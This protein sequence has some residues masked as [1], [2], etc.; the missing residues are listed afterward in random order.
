MKSRLLFVALLPMLILLMVIN[1][2]R[3]VA[4]ASDP[5]GTMVS[6]TEALRALANG[7][8]IPVD[9]AD[10]LD[11]LPSFSSEGEAQLL[12]PESSNTPQALSGGI[13]FA[14][15]RHG[16]F[17]IFIQNAAETGSANLLVG[18]G[19]NDVTPVWSPDG[20]Q[21]VFASERDGDFEIFLRQENGTEI[22][23]TNNTVVDIHPSWSPDG[24]RILFTSNRGGG[25]YQA[26]TM[27]LTGGG[28]QQVGSVANNVLYPR[29]SPD[30]SRIVFMRASIA[31]P[32]CDWNWD[33]WLMNANG[34]NQERV[35]TQLGGDIYPNW[36]PEG[37]IIYASCR[38]FLTSNLYIVNPESGVETQ[39]TD[40]TGSEMHAVYSP[41][42]EYLAFNATGEGNYEIYVA[43]LSQGTSFRFTSDSASDL[44]P[45]WTQQTLGS[46]AGAT[47]RQPIL[48]VTGWGGS[49]DFTSLSDDGQLKY[50]INHLATHGY[51]EDCNLFYAKDI[52]PY[53]YLYI[54][55]LSPEG[56]S[57]ATIIR[58]NLCEYAPLVAQ[59][60]PGWSGSFDIV[61]HS[62]GGLRARAF[63]EREEIY[64]RDLE[65]GQ[66][67]IE[68][69][70]LS[71]RV[72]I[73][74]L[75]TM[76][77][78]H[79][80]EWPTLP[81]SI[82]IG[83]L[84]LLGD[85]WGVIDPEIPAML[86]MMPPIR[87]M[88]NLAHSQPPDVTYY[89]IGGNVYDQ[90]E[91]AQTR[92]GLLSS[93]WYLIHP[94]ENDFAVHTD[95]AHGTTLLDGRYPNV[96]ETTTADIHGQV[97]SWLDP[98]GVLN[99]YVNPGTTFEQK[100]C[101][102]IVDLSDCQT[103][104]FI[105]ADAALVWNEHTDHLTG[106]SV[107]LSEAQQTP[108]TPM[109]DIQAGVVAGSET[110]SG[111]F[112]LNDAGES[113]IML[114]W[115]AG[116][117]TLELVDPDGKLI[118]S[119][120]AE[121]D[122]NIDYIQFPDGFGLSTSYHMTTT[123]TGTWTYTISAD[124]LEA[125]TGYRLAAIPATPIGVTGSMPLW[126]PNGE[127]AVITATV[128]Y[129][130]STPVPGAEVTLR[131][132]RPDNTSAI[133]TL[134]DDGNHQDG[135]ADDGVYGA[136]Y[137][138][139]TVGG[140]YGLVFTA[141]GNYKGADYERTAVSYFTVAPSSASLGGA[142]SDKGISNNIFGLYEQL[143]V[144][145][146]VLVNKE[147]SYLLSAQLF[148]GDTLITQA[149]T[150]LNLTPGNHTVPLLFDGT[151]IRSAQLNGPFTVQN[152]LLLDETQVTILVE[153]VENAYTTASYQ[154][155]AF[156][157]P[158]KVYLPLVVR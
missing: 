95:S 136:T 31:I 24:S 68:C 91:I 99:S 92:L 80:G 109:I 42:G 23:L 145:A 21:L 16:P 58:D 83:V 144:T 100:I 152:L 6:D 75:F 3:V 44:T 81:F 105:L 38:N 4:T 89:F 70:G 128:A 25:Y 50:F 69:S 15:D 86:E 112:V 117:V 65:N 130:G 129:D 119:Q 2:P 71:G 53:R 43:T 60:I 97:P 61:A 5:Q 127:P 101:P 135:V 158:T 18:G 104:N 140:L 45:S 33:I 143:E 103:A 8:L 147:G 114:A 142:Y 10:S 110:V 94:L 141:S 151:E 88:Q 107:N 123:V 47:A 120:S 28:V 73:D 34:T 157:I 64:N 122:P 85:E 121:S 134:I 77:T 17:N 7:R 62:Y 156:G 54:D 146:E 52:S 9:P 138:Q 149:T 66:I 72:W 41:D 35:T 126:V 131:I 132:R 155:N 150:R 22:Q 93:F 90:G 56:R 76:G 11:I 82:G 74:N 46:C 57:N 111:Q 87:M 37:N 148:S 27:N 137:D 84:A 118:D 12:L 98:A 48:L 78:P 113:V 139:T 36:T 116:S 19:S 39:L 106:G 125:P 1:L 49:E 102:Y 67:G 115:G 59:A 40:W 13:A 63:L 96:Y 108:A 51:V 55:E 124:S 29:Y 26:Y 79:D 30:G 154:F 133:I 20:K 32:A 14:S 153:E